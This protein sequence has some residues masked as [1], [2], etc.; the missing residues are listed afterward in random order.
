MASLL[1]AYVSVILTLITP[2][3]SVILEK[4]QLSEADFI[5][6]WCS[7][8]QYDPDD[9]VLF[10]SCYLPT[11]QDRG[12]DGL[13][14]VAGLRLCQGL[15]TGADGLSTEELAVFKNVLV[16]DIAAILRSVNYPLNLSQPIQGIIAP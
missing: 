1:R 6:L 15:Y 8:F 14:D 2:Y 4:T 9:M 11:F 5:N 12:L 16:D 10:D 7:V 3:K 13:M